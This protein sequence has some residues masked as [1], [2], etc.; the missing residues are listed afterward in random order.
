MN[1]VN[2][3]IIAAIVVVIFAMVCHFKNQIMEFVWKIFYRRVS[4]EKLEKLVRCQYEA[5]ELNRKAY[6]QE[7][8]DW[9]LEMAKHLC[10]L[11]TGKLS[12]AQTFCFEDFP[13]HLKESFAE[14]EQELR[15]ILDYWQEAEKNLTY[16]LNRRKYFNT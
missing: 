12:T 8:V 15:Q 11:W 1:E 4:D 7:G 14:K 13:E 6:N 5:Y 3:L 9:L 16:E 2:F 10:C